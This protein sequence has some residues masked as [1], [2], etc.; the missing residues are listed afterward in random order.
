[1]VPTVIAASETPM[2]AKAG[3]QLVEQAGMPPRPH[4]RIGAVFCLV[5]AAEFLALL[6]QAFGILHPL[7]H[8]LPVEDEWR[9]AGRIQDVV[10]VIDRQHDTAV[11]AGEPGPG[12]MPNPYFHPRVG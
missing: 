5:C 9:S 4:R 6:P 12:R 7:G 8:N 2:A 1:M 3:R 11:R 10:M